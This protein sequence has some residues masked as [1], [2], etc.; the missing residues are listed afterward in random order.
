MTRIANSFYSA[1]VAHKEIDGL[2][3]AS[4]G[5]PGLPPEWVMNGK[6]GKPDVFRDHDQAVLAGF[7][8]L[9]A[10]LNRARQEQDFHVKGQANGKQNTIKR[11]KA[12]QAQNEHTVDSVFGKKK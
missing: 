10:K 3:H 11:W 4:F 5:I 9:I 7:R 2:Y 1:A 8:V 6:D 12:P